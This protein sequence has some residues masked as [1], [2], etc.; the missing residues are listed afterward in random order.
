MN[1]RALAL[2][3]AASGL[4]AQASRAADAKAGMP[5]FDL[6]RF[7]GQIFWLALTFFV[8]YWIMSK[9]ALPRIGE[10]LET[11]AR[12][13]GDDLDRA[14][15]LKGEADKV[16]T[17]YEKTLAEARAKAQDVGRATEAALTKEATDRQAVLGNELTQRIR[18]A[19]ARIAAAKSTAMGNLAGVAAEAARQAVDRVAGL[20]VSADEAQAAARSALASR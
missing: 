8:L 11:R 4:L 2:T 19:E 12:R 20:S 18:E 1:L 5:Q 17:A 15:S 9:V 7:P 14:A 13:I 10:V 16:R 3:V 6:A